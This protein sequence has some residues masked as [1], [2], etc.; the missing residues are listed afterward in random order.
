MIMIV[1][2]MIFLCSVC[3]IVYAGTRIKNQKAKMI[4]LIICILPAFAS[5]VFILITIYFAWAVSVN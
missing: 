3:G 5:A 2:V 1:A 4:C